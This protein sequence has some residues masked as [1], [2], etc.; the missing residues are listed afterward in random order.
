[1]PN[2]F[3]DVLQC[4]MVRIGIENLLKITKDAFILLCQI[5][6]SR[7]N[8]KNAEEIIQTLQY[9]LNNYRSFLKVCTG[10]KFFYFMYFILTL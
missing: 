10:L 7:K 3:S 1:L 8:D 5:A 2:E 6:I 4:L 9:S